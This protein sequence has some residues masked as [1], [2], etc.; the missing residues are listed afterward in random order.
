MCAPTDSLRRIRFG[1]HDFEKQKDP[2]GEH[3]LKDKEKLVFRY[4]VILHNGDE[5]E[6]RIAERYAAFAKE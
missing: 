5:T 3:T 6:G 2:V 1:I 4:R